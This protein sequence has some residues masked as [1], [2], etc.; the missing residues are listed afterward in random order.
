MTDDGVDT[1]RPPGEY[2]RSAPAAAT[3][4]AGES[5]DLYIV[6]RIGEEQF[7]VPGPAVDEVIERPALTPLPEIL[8]GVRGLVRQA[9]G[10]VPV[11][12][13]PELPA[14]E[15]DGGR[16]AVAIIL[17]RGRL[18]YAIAADEVLGTRS[19]TLQE[20]AEHWVEDDMV[21]SILDPEA[22]FGD[23]I[24]AGWERREEM[25][26]DQVAE[27]RRSYVIFTLAGEDFA[28]PADAVKEIRPWERLERPQHAPDFLAG[29]G[30]TPG[31]SVPV[32]DLRV[33][34]GLHAEEPGGESRLVL[35]TA[36]G[37]T[38]GLL[39][40]GVR[41]VAHIAAPDALETPEY[42][43]RLVGAHVG[44][45]LRSE[46]D[47]LVVVLRSDMLFD[48]SQRQDLHSF[49]LENAEPASG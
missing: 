30:R 40:D 21:V 6:F 22:L 24:P 25:D 39:V 10:R 16:A 19:G 11:L 32:V 14:A 23:R 8:N 5:E 4:G 33:H 46:A 41:D 12:E 18:S 7:A 43:R 49:V 31:G 3:G 13:L 1:G 15:M 28:L 36:E 2:R 26:I 48:S 42:L 47:R 9:G 37:D 45:L 20:D 34:L 27:K 29:I 17:R 44:G 38:I 35:T